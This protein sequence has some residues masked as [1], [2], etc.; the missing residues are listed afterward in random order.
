MENF[1]KKPLKDKIL[2]AFIFGIFLG[3]FKGFLEIIF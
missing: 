3:I 2:I 1:W